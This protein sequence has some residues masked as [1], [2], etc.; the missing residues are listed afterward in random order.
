MREIKNFFLEYQVQ[1]GTVSF[2]AIC[3]GEDTQ[4]SAVR[5]DIQGYLREVNTFHQRVRKLNS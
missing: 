2:R 1:A 5:M 3:K 4:V